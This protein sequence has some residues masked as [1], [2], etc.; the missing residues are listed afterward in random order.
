MRF[1]APRG[2]G[3]IK[4]PRNCTTSCGGS[5]RLTRSE[6]RHQRLHLRL[7]FR[8]FFCIRR[9]VFVDC[10]A[11]DGDTAL[12]YQTYAAASIGR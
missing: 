10:G 8:T 4:H 9:F 12:K 6:F 7:T 1:N 5:S 3:A 2:S 11:F